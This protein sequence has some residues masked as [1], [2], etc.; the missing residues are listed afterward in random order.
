[1]TTNRIAIAPLALV[2]LVGLATC[3]SNEL[4][5]FPLRAPLA[6]DPDMTPFAPKPA[7]FESPAV[8][9]TVDN[10]LFE[11]L[12]SAL[13][14]RSSRR[15]PNVTA[16]DEVADSSWFTNRVDTLAAAEDLSVWRKGAC[17]DDPRI[18]GELTVIGGKPNGANPGFM[19]Q[20]ANGDKFLYKL[21]D[22]AS[23]G[24]ASTADL[25]GSRL[26]YAAGYF[27]PCNRVA[28][29]DP[30]KI[31]VSPKAMTEDF[32]G[33]KVPFT[34]E[35][36]A[37]A[38]NKG[39][40]RAD[41]KVRGSLSTLIE[42]PGLG[43]WTDF[44]V[45]P[46]DPNDVIPHEDRRELRGSYIFAAL[47]SHYDAR[48]QNTYDVW[49]GKDRGYVRHYM[50]D[51]GDCLG[52]SST[53]PR[54]W[55]RR[56]HVYEIDWSTALVDFITLGALDRPWRDPHFGPTGTALG[57]YNSE[58]FDPEQFRTAYPFG[59]FTHLTEA[60]AAWGARILARMSPAAISAVVDEAQLTDPVIRKT[61][62]DVILARREAL[63][64]RYLSKLSPLANPVVEVT[65]TVA[66]LC[67]RDRMVDAK[68]SDMQSRPLTATLDGRALAVIEHCA[69]LPQASGPYA[70][71]E[72]RAGPE[73]PLRVHLGTIG[74][75]YAVVGL[76]R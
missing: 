38:M 44:G 43:P 69:Q 52:S 67:V 10:L 55:R 72:L 56:S 17:T 5:P 49:V 68:L 58:D 8:W 19:L 18:E 15:A 31:K 27:A 29:I 4:R 45:R 39:L 2:G 42:G 20:D 37:F 51:F 25:I 53:R 46:D 41:G 59:P 12:T 64:R 14:L 61:L 47:L 6:A 22:R 7:K 71:V 62:L 50:L 75:H 60:D 63:L 74:Q 54:V 13:A 48:E 57:Y 21:D 76:D 9:D 11:P 1:M 23:G 40:K 70:I 34:K 16:L 33:K 65:G 28:F 30:A 26:Y 32:V 35:M 3:G 24:R 66:Q 36:L 73:A